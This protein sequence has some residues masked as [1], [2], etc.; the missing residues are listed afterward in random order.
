M[1]VQSNPR[2]DRRDYE[3][4]ASD[5][6]EDT[7]GAKQAVLGKYPTGRL[8]ERGRRW[9]RRELPARAKRRRG[10]ERPPDRR[11]LSG[12]LRSRR[13][14][15]GMQVTHVEFLNPGTYTFEVSCNDTGAGGIEL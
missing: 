10:V 15:R 9:Q 13:A 1:A 6:D 12:E 7:E 8:S 3:A 4:Q 11:A 5:A 14:A 2:R